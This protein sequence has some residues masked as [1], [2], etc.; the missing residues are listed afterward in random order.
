MVRKSQS[1]RFRQER[2]GELT[3]LIK[4]REVRY[5][6]AIAGAFT[7]LT[8]ILFVSDR[9]IWLPPERIVTVYRVHG[10]RCAFEWERELE[11]AGFSVRMNEVDSLKFIRQRMRTPPY[12]SGCHV[13]EY[14][15]YF[16][17]DHVPA[18]ALSYLSNSRPAATGL[19]MPGTA[20]HLTPGAGASP[21]QQIILRREDGSE[22]LISIGDHPSLPVSR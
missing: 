2:R 14:L 17:E 7:L 5:G 13:G 8:A 15:G 4:R 18:A 1:R 10:C 3:S 20:R 19:L 6:I 21:T 22:S 11:R 12:A 9:S 16:L